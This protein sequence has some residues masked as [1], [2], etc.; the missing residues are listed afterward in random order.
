MFALLCEVP[1]SA[2]FFLKFETFTVCCLDNW[3]SS[4]RGKAHK[5]EVS[6][7]APEVKTY[8]EEAE[9]RPGRFIFHV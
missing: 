2:G 9:S 8:V 5:D 4:L 6:D 7:T 1:F 3:Y